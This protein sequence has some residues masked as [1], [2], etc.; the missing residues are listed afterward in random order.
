MV[1]YFTN[2][3]T[4]YI[5]AFVCGDWQQVERDQEIMAKVMKRIS[6]ELKKSD[7]KG[8]EDGIL[9]GDKIEKIESALREIRN[10]AFNESPEKKNEKLLISTNDFED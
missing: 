7:I 6:D 5:K 2:F 1:Q 9:S 10:D 4:N 3:D 8:K